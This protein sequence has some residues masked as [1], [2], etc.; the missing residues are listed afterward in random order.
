MYHRFFP[1]QNDASALPGA[2]LEANPDDNN[3]LH[4]L[5]NP[6]E[7]CMLAQFNTGAVA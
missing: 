2:T 3:R 6:F 4:I 7:K 5:E 1:V